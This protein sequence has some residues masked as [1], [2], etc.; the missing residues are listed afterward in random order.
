M[1]SL[2]SLIGATKFKNMK[3][4][5]TNTLLLLALVVNTQFSSAQELNK[6]F[7]SNC[8]FIAAEA[9]NASSP[10]D[11]SIYQI[12]LSY[13]YSPRHDINAKAVYMYNIQVVNMNTNQIV[14]E[15]NVYVNKDY[16]ESNDVMLL[17]NEVHSLDL[18]I[19]R[20]V[21]FYF[22]QVKDGSLSFKFDLK[23]ISS[24]RTYKIHKVEFYPR[25]KSWQN[26]TDGVTTYDME[27][28]YKHLR[29]FFTHYDKE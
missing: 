27:K 21:I 13:E 12:Y 8:A 7:T 4:I 26:K 9:R 19:P 2:Y 5:I 18:N 28:A 3:S 14:Q 20:N 10:D 17:N 23:D 24:S 16:L 1:R 25:K 11:L 29:Y 15:S 6:K 22:S